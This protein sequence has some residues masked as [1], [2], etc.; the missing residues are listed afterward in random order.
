MSASFWNTLNPY[1]PWAVIDPD[2]TLD[3]PVEIEDW[4]ASLGSSYSSHKVI[5][6][7]PL[8][9]TIS[10]YSAGVITMRVRV[11]ASPEA[12]PGRRYSLTV[13]LTLSD[14]QK[15]DRSLLLEIGER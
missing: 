6:E 15:Q 1:S 10:T 5:A 12:E 11:T 8:E 4:V 2:D 9:C 14:G 13:R 7:A 3:L